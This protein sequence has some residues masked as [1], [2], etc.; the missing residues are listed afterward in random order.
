MSQEAEW[1]DQFAGLK[2]L[3]P[4]VVDILMRNSAVVSLPSGSRIYGPGQAPKSYLLLLDGSVRVQQVSETGREIVLYRVSAGESCAL[5]T[6]CLMGY[7]DYPA[8]AIA[9]TDI[10]AVAIPRTTFEELIARSHEFRR[11]VFTAFSTRVTNLFRIIEEIAFSR[12]DIRLAHKILELSHGADDVTSTQQQ[13][14][15]ELGTAREVVSRIFAEFQR[16]GWL[17]V[18]RG[19]IKINNRPALERLASEH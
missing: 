10:H 14:A 3:P 4:D 6:A 17:V 8:E 2:R 19:H 5:T 15:S 11:F 7:E 16:R 13:I 18:T 1:I 9:E 12:M